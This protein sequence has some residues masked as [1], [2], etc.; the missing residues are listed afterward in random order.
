MA[1]PTNDYLYSKHFYKPITCNT[2][3][4]SSVLASRTSFSNHQPICSRSSA[5]RIHFRPTLSD[6]RPYALG[7]GID[8]PRSRR[9]RLSKPL[10]LYWELAYD[11]WPY[12]DIVG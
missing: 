8:H 12:A 7:K 11:N 1:L 4:A 9:T 3:T 6:H 2:R 10:M 5:N